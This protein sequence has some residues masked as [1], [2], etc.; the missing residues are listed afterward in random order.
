MIEDLFV[1]GL[2]DLGGPAGGSW[3]AWG[4][5]LEGLRVDPSP[6]W[7]DSMPAPGLTN[8]TF[9]KLCGKLAYMNTLIHKY[10][11]AD[12]II[13][14]ESETIGTHIHAHVDIDSMTK[15]NMHSETFY[16][17]VAIL[18]HVGWCKS[19]SVSA[20]TTACS[21]VVDR[22]YLESNLE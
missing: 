20:I 22:R 10:R 13:P 18:V 17:S 7:M 11:N 21:C 1:G 9:P 4:W 19:W 6:P 14:I 3:G 15:T 2:N 12:F 5:I 16:N 8:S